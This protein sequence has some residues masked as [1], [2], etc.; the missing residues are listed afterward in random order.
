M[1]IIAYMHGPLSHSFTHTHLKA[2]TYLIRARYSYTITHIDSR[3]SNL[4]RCNR[5]A[6]LIIARSKNNSFLALFCSCLSQPSLYTAP[7]VCCLTAYCLSLPTDS[8]TVSAHLSLPLFWMCQIAHGRMQVPS[9][10]CFM[11]TARELQSL[12]GTLRVWQSRGG[13]IAAYRLQSPLEIIID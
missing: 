10:S 7:S 11:N 2:H 1:H 8:V 5:K 12:N 4:A 6:N 13:V 9:V 3:L